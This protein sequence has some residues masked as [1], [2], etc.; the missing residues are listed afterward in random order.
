MS[1]N[2]GPRVSA[3]VPPPNSSSEDI[4][5]LEPSLRLQL[6]TDLGDLRLSLSQ[7]IC[8]GMD[9]VITEDEIVRMLDGGPEYKG[10]IALGFKFYGSIGFLEHRD[11]AFHDLRWCCHR[12]LMHSNP[13]NRVI[14][15][16]FVPPAF[17]SLQ[18]ERI[19]ERIVSSNLRQTVTYT[20][21]AP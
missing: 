11:F 12:T 20:W 15:R 17:T 1:N 7:R 8:A 13:R 14:M 2:L 10:G 6:S 5:G 21:E 16:R 18:S 19:V 4:R 3:C 9:G